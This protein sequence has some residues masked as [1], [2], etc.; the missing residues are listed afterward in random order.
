MINREREDIEA[1]LLDAQ[2]N[3]IKLD[4]ENRM[5]K[6]NL[7]V[8]VEI[9]EK[10]TGIFKKINFCPTWCFPGMKRSVKLNYF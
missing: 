6:P 1:E 3:M 8:L 5:L 10:V 4:D 9:I 2:K 7:D